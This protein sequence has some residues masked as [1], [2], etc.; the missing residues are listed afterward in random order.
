MRPNAP[1]GGW[2]VVAGAILAATLVYLLVLFATGHDLSNARDDFALLGLVSAVAGLIGWRKALRSAERFRAEAKED[3]MEA[4]SLARRLETQKR[5][6]AEL[7]QQLQK[8]QQERGL[9][10]STNDVPA[11]VLKTAIS[12]VGAEKGLLLSREDEDSDGD[13]DLLAAEGFQH[14]P[15]HSAIAQRFAGDVIAKDVTIRDKDPTIPAN[16]T[17]A[18][19]EINNLLAIPIYV[20]DKFSGA[21]VLANNPQ[22]FDDHDDDV[23]LALG[24]HAGAAL[25]NERLHGELRAAYLATVSMLAE[26]VEAKDPFLRSHSSDATRFVSAVA[27][28]L[29]MDRREREDLV[30]GSL[31]HD[32]GKIG[33]SERILLKPG[34]LTAH[35]RSLI[36]LHPRIGFR[37]VQQ[38]PALRGVAPAIL[39]HHERFD[40]AGYPGKLTGDEIPLAARIISVVD[41]FSA[42]TS[43]RPYRDARPTEEALEELERCAGTQFDPEIVRLFAEEVRRGPKEQ[44]TA[45]LL[46]AALSDPEIAQRRSGDEPRLGFDSYSLTDN[47]TMLYCHRRFHEVAEGEA[48]RATLQGVPFAVILVELTDLPELN[49]EQGYAA[50]DEAIRTVARA[51]QAAALSCGGTAARYS[52]RRLGVVVPRAGQAEAEKCL[53][54]IKDELNGEVD[55]RCTCFVWRPGQEGQDVIDRAVAELAEKISAPV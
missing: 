54:D 21:V 49:R 26:A 10:G 9:L 19:G 47:L 8:L 29:G 15:S 33:I 24:D 35:E 40:G 5:W 7:R 3:R 42:M 39:H 50:G 37:I 38:V 18:D 30:F 34:P 20:R 45:E 6:N 48:K 4:E 11:L 17:P 23:L 25:H 55:V 41:A 46:V 27:E 28:R 51:V 14:D 44:D 12:L 2:F 31:L 16:A 43:D 13:L 36:E 52:G 53:E 32:V 1:G 22:G